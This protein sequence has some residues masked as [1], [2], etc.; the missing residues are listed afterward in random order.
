M[1]QTQRPSVVYKR[2]RLVSGLRFDIYLI[3]KY[4]VCNR[5]KNCYNIHTQCRFLVP[6]NTQK[7][8][9]EI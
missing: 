7:I 2:E 8:L 4:V 9:M 3:L 1:V 5:D 6:G